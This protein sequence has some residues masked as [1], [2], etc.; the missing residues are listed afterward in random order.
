ME[1][2]QRELTAW[3]IAPDFLRPQKTILKLAGSAK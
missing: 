3:I 2:R 1:E